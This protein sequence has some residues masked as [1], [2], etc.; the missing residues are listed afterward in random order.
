VPAKA[1]REAIFIESE[2]E[3][4]MGTF[5]S[6]KTAI[7]GP[8]SIELAKREAKVVAAP[9]C[10][11]L[12]PAWIAE[13]HGALVTDVDGNTFIDL[14]GGW[15]CLAVGHSHPR[16][17]AAIKDQAEHF[18][19]TDFTSVP[20]ETYV[21]VCE[22]L[23]KLT[24]GDFEKS[25]ALFNNGAE[26]I[27]NAVKISRHVTGRTGVVVFD[28]A[29][30]G[31]TLL[32]MT[33]T[34]KAKPYKDGFGPFAPDVYRMPYVTP[35]HPSIR[36]EEW[37][38]LLTTYVDPSTVACFVV[39]PVQGEGGFRV[40]TDG[41]LEMLREV[42][43][44]YGILLVVDEIQA[45]IGRTGKFFSI[46]N[47][48][49]VPDIICTAKSLAA[50]MPLS[51]VIAR[52]DIMDKLP[53]SSIGGTYV[54][55]PVACRA[56]SEVIDIIEGEHLLDRAIAL[57]KL[58][59]SHWDAWKEKYQIIGDVRGIGAMQAIEFVKDRTTR[60]PATQLNGEIIKECLHNGVFVAGS[61]I[62][63]NCI[64]MLVSLEIT[65]EQL[66]EAFGIM[67]TAVAHANESR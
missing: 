41:F 13:G 16:V 60:E 39:E 64:R 12:S 27:E 17:T 15:G 65:D 51:A 14:T 45:G 21:T 38:K 58:I 28:R 4:I 9:M 18:L 43:K 40:P 3:V 5:I 2:R 50:G 49:V 46:E 25:V 11:A 33:M 55:N 10:D 48:N 56:A 34:H 19:H 53:S 23:A 66:E 57:G 44:K 8:K 20:Y 52:K 36:I 67:E 61:G 59:R 29:F 37:E 1:K 26:A 6:L 31:R 22:K 54:G 47:W 63:G 42:S 35:Y 24:P 62:Y 7:P 32:T 30:H